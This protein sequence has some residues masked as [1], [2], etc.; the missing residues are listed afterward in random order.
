MGEQKR[1]SELI[2]KLK[3]NRERRLRGEYITIPFK[4]KSLQDN[5]FGIQRKSLYIVTAAPGVGKTQITKALF[6]HGIYD[7]ILKYGIKAHIYYYALEESN[8]KFDLTILTKSLKNLFDI[9]KS[10][11]YLQSFGENILD[12]ETLQKLESLEEVFNNLHKYITIVD[13]LT[14]VDEIY[15]D[16]VNRLASTGTF[17][18]TE[19]DEEETNLIYKPN[20]ENRFDI[21]IVDHVSLLTSEKSAHETIKKWSKQYSLGIFVKKFGATVINVQQQNAEQDKSQFDMKGNVIVN[22][23]LPS[24]SGLADNKTTFQDADYVITLFDPNKYNIPTMNNYNVGQMGNHV[25]IFSCIKARFGEMF[26]TALY[27][28][29]KTN[30]FIELPPANKLTI[31]HYKAIKAGEYKQELV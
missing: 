20:E 19:N 23:V 6:V 18:E 17:E 29:G 12:E 13:H 3:D 26:N 8:E 4:H 14:D 1:F 28:N 21:I 31:N 30:E 15:S 25:R 2:A 10:Y 27:F 11:A 22:K 5:L 7:A 24:M 16:V 9:D